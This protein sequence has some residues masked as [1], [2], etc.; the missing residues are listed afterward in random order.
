MR[1]ENDTLDRLRVLPLVVLAALLET[2]WERGSRRPESG[3]PAD[4]FWWAEVRIESV[5][6]VHPHDPC[7]AIYVPG[8]V[9][10]CQSLSAEGV[11]EMIDGFKR[12]VRIII[13]ERVKEP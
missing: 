1:W 4:S 10:A 9:V 11:D 6:V 12:E 13:R 3:R 2:P 8:F 5:N 7:R